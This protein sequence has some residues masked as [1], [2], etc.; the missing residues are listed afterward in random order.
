MK[1]AKHTSGPWGACCAGLGQN[2]ERN[3]TLVKTSLTEWG[4]A[5][6]DSR[7]IA[8]A[9]DLLRALEEARAMLATAKR[10]FPKSIQNSDRFELLNVL[11]NSVEPAIKKARGE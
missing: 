5:I 1:E 11:A 8:A 3:I 6:A 9:P 2:N 7:L 10:Y 4:D